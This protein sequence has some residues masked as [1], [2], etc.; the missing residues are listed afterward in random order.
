MGNVL[1]A[2]ALGILA[3]ALGPIS[4]VRSDTDD[5]AR[6]RQ[7][8]NNIESI[9]GE[10]EASRG[11]RDSASKALDE[12]EARIRKRSKAE[13]RTKNEIATTTAKIVEL[14]AELKALDS[15]ISDHRS[16]LGQ[17]L[18]SAHAGGRDPQLKILLGQTDPARIER[19]LRWYR[20]VAK[21]RGD[22]IAELGQEARKVKQVRMS[23][24]EKQE[25]LKRL[26]NESEQNRSQ[27]A[28]QRQE[29]KK[30]LA[31]LGKDIKSRESRA[32]SLGNDAVAL[33]NL[34]R[35]VEQTSRRLQIQEQRETEARLREAKAAKPFKSLKGTLPMPVKGKISAAFGS[36]KRGF[37]GDITWQGVLINADDG[38]SVRAVAGGEVI[39]AGSRIR[40]AGEIIMID[41]GN[42]FVTVYMHN[43]E[44][45]R[46]TGDVVTAG[47]EIAYVGSSGLDRPGL[48]FRINHKSTALDPVAWLKR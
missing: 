9:E 27:L 48:L 13:R 47:E 30:L 23:L 35:E 25:S 28:A 6:L 16:R 7:L 8:R 1:R 41:H 34:I 15:R 36:P 45:L 18:R 10:L 21:A 39:Y 11:K 46:Q 5:S 43:S 32:R 4:E 26:Q 19:S 3:F 22:A 20:Y 31:R 33:E 14:G 29:K 12:I 38:S 37:E 17:L 42:D 2:G 44:L 40:G 24:D